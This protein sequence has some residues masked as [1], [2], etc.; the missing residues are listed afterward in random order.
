MVMGDLVLKEEEVNPVMSR[1]ISGGIN[2]TALHNH[3]MG[4]SPSIM[5]MHIDGHGNPTELA[6]TFR[7]GIKK[8]NTPIK[9]VTPR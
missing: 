4:E 7:S 6:K 1:L 5:Y 8:S 2:V 3:L 9:A